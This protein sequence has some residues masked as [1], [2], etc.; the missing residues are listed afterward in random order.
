MPLGIKFRQKPFSKITAEIASKLSCWL[1]SNWLY[2][3]LIGF[4]R[5]STIFPPNKIISLASVLKKNHVICKN[6]NKNIFHFFHFF[7]TSF[8]SYFGTLSPT[9]SL[10]ISTVSTST[11]CP[12]NIF[13]SWAIG[14]GRNSEHFTLNSGLLSRTSSYNS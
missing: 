3:V 1:T 11:T 12:S 4:Y 2:L 9:K 14:T 13:F 6:V 8:F 5:F 7:F 10:K